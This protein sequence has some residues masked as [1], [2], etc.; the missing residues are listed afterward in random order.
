MASPE[1]LPTCIATAALLYYIVGMKMMSI[2]LPDPVVAELE[3]EAKERGI[4]KTDLVRESIEQRRRQKRAKVP[5]DLAD[6]I[7][8]IDGLPEDLSSRKKY[9]LRQG[10]GRKPHR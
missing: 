9:Y 10:Y 8:C 6:I 4:S 1:H 2:R 3:A 5:D 7:G